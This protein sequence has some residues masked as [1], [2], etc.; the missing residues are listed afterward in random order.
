MNSIISDIK[1]MFEKY[2][3]L[4]VELHGFKN[5]GQSESNADSEV[6]ADI[7]EG[8]IRYIIMK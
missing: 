2:D 8:T 5:S 7:K 4:E 1:Y 6:S 3:T